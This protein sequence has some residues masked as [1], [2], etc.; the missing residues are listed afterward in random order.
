MARMGR[1]SGPTL[2][3]VMSKAPPSGQPRALSNRPDPRDTERPAAS[4]MMTPGRVLRLPIGFAWMIGGGLVLAIVLSY[5]VGYS[6]GQQIADDDA[7]RLSAGLAESMRESTRVEDPLVTPDVPTPLARVVD[8]VPVVPRVTPPPRQTPQRATTS[9]IREPGK[10]YFVAETPLAV[11]AEEICT[12]IRGSG[13]DAMV[14]PTEN[15]RFRQV[16]VLP[17]YDPGDAETRD[18]LRQRIIEIGRRF[19]KQ[20]RNNDNF[21]DTYSAVYRR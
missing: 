5:V 13:L 3:E 10:A 2:Y 19:E 14:V 9:R 1:R 4:R 17:G 15:T 18:R 12:F 21:D 16:I 8:E 7:R 11:R 6:R 20:S